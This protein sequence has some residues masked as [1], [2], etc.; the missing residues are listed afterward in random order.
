MKSLLFTCSIAVLLST[1]CASSTDPASVAAVSISPS[2]V[3][4]V[5]GALE[6]MH[7]EATITGPSGSILSGRS[8][9]WSSSDRKIATV[10]ADGVV[11]GIAQGTAIITAT[12]EGKSGSATVKVLPMTESLTGTWISGKAGS[13]VN[14]EL[15]LT[16]ANTETVT[17]QW[18]G[19]AA[20]CSPAN[21]VQCQR[22]GL[23]V[24]GY[25]HGSSAQFVMTPGSTCGVGDATVTAMFAR[26]DSLAALVTEHNCNASDATP[27][28]ATLTRKK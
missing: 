28:G 21:S 23:V 26:F 3:Q 9:L 8:V 27:T 13:I 18:S 15:Q 16:E 4:L 25:R 14:L 7:L 1:G 2:T 12:S 20:D 11:N 10:S 24:S 22:S 19:Y 6:Q 17:G 5:A